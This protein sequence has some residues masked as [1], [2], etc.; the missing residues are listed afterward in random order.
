MMKPGDAMTNENWE[1]LKHIMLAHLDGVY[2]FS[3]RTNCDDLVTILI[4]LLISELARK[5]NGRI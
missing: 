4:Q 3:A 1:K 5:N 2:V